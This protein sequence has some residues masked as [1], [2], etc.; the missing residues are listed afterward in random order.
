MLVRNK[1]LGI[2]ILILIYSNKIS[3]DTGFF[4]YERPKISMDTVEFFLDTSKNIN[5]ETERLK[6]SIKELDK[7]D[8]N[9]EKHNKELEIESNKNYLKNF[10]YEMTKYGAN[11]KECILSETDDNYLKI[12]NK[13]F[14]SGFNAFCGFITVDKKY[15]EDFKYGNKIIFDIEIKSDIELLSTIQLNTEL[16]GDYIT[17]NRSSIIYKIKTGQNKYK[18]EYVFKEVEEGVYESGINSFWFNL[19]VPENKNVEIKI[20]GIYKEKAVT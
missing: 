3:A 2:G 1:I 15:I 13:K 10:N 19:I 12:E 4:N 7:E 17:E 6:A 8:I 9:K 14:S 5:I 20:K 18:L 11:N 16:K